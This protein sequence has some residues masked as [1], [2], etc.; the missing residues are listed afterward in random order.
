M[1]RTLLDSEKNIIEKIINNRYSIEEAQ[2]HNDFL[3][4]SFKNKSYSFENTEIF[5]FICNIITANKKMLNDHHL[6]INLKI[7]EILVPS[8]LYYQFQIAHMDTPNHLHAIGIINKPD[9][10]IPFSIFNLSNI[11]INYGD[12]PIIKFGPSSC[13]AVE[14][15]VIYGLQPSEYLA[16]ENK[17]NELLRN[18]QMEFNE[19]SLQHTANLNYHYIIDESNLNDKT[20]SLVLS[21]LETSDTQSIAKKIFESIKQQRR[22]N[23]SVALHSIYKKFE[24][25]P[26]G[27][28]TSL[29]SSPQMEAKKC[30]LI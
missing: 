11:R 9:G 16:F 23:A 26:T 15:L 18:K 28:D 5:N 19:D 24:N 30:K 13:T 22:A 14:Q 7:E 2:T 29:F 3:I 8:C 6:E 10:N 25:K 21:Y 1:L 17:F 4:R 27:Q 12:N 20:K